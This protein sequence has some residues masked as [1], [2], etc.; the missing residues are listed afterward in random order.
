VCY[1]LDESFTLFVLAGSEQVGVVLESRVDVVEECIRPVRIC[2]LVCLEI[3]DSCFDNNELA[4]GQCDGEYA[5]I[6]FISP[7][8]LHTDIELQIEIG[9]FL[10]SIINVLRPG[11]AFNLI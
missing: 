8:H 10:I 3:G 2:S 9:K 6:R 5:F 1:L 11:R 4:G 7:G